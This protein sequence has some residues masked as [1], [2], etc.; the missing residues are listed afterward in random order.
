MALLLVE[1][2]TSDIQGWLRTFESDPMNRG[3][4][5]V[6]RSWIH[7]DD[8]DTATIVL[9]MEF[10]SAEAAAE[11][12]RV[13]EPVW[14]ISGAQRAWV[15]R[16]KVASSTH[17]SPVTDRS[18]FLYK[19]MPPRP[20]FPMD[21]SESEAAVMGRHVDYWSDQVAAGRALFFGP[22]ADPTGA[23]GFAVVLADT[24]DQVRAM[25]KDDPAVTTG[26]GS[27]EVYAIPGA[28]SA[29]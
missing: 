19:L 25:S 24:E 1:Y 27:Y 18:Y 3:A 9:A 15:L 23:W 6:T 29:Q 17:V 10:P 4:H 20:S 12:R 26:L 2:Q 5:G 16:D 8:G 13:L 11:F 21:M 7:H 14:E 28:V 22:V